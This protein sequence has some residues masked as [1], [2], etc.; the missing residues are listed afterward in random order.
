[1]DFIILLF[2]NLSYMTIYI[3]LINIGTIYNLKSSENQK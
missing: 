3:L 1:M 2:I